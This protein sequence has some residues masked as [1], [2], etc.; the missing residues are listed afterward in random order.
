M[1]TS[2]LTE[3]FGNLKI[4]APRVPPSEEVDLYL[5]RARLA[6]A[7]E[8]FDVARVFCEKA[9]VIEPE[10]LEVLLF[11]A[12]VLDAGFGDADAAIALYQKI[13]A[14]AGY[15]GSNPYCAAAR[16]A[17]ADLASAAT[18]QA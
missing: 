4:R 11:L 6:A 16:E 10:N 18:H 15:D 17:V 12:R 5:R 9:R 1:K 7:E 3:K 14:R 2:S 8:R 13:I